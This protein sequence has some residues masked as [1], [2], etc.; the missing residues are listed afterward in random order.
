ME[1]GFFYQKAG[2]MP[3]AINRFKKVLKEY[4]TTSHV[5]E[6]LYRLSACYY[7]MGVYTEAKRYGAVLGSNFPDSKWYQRS[8]DMLQKENS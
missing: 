8:Y 2:I 6:A 5:P 1:I 3:A 4:D 7:S